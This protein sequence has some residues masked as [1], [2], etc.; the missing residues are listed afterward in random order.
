VSESGKFDV[1][2]VTTLAYSYADIRIIR[3]R[4]LYAV[5]LR[6]GQHLQ[7]LFFYTFPAVYRQSRGFVNG[8]EGEKQSARREGVFGR[9]SNEFHEPF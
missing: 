4:S 8:S 9:F 7:P 5:F 6:F 2:N 3:D 1:Q